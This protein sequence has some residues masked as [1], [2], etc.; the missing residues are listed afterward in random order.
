MVE[1]TRRFFLGGTIALIAAQTFKPSISQGSNLPKI[2]ADGIHNDSAG[3]SALFTNQPVIFNKDQIGV[4]SHGGATILD[5]YTIFKID[6]TVDVSRVGNLKV[7]GKFYINAKDLS[8]FDPLF[9]YEY[10]SFD[11]S[12]IN[13]SLDMKELRRVPLFKITDD[14]GKALDPGNFKGKF[15]PPI[16]GGTY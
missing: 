7:D 1:L 16:D 15:M 10:N 9:S 12:N 2:W 6:N 4:D 5:K 3:L 14:E 13:F 11:P 8:E